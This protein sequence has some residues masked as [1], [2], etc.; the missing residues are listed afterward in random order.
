VYAEIKVISM[1]THPASQL[2]M[3]DYFAVFCGIVLTFLQS[4]AKFT[5]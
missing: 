4:A 1:Q 2:E 5:L 3:Y